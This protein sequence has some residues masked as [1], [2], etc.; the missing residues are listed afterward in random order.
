VPI[1][2]TPTTPE[3]A[4]ALL[5]EADAAGQRVRLMGG[6]TKAGWG[7]PGG[8]AGVD[9]KI[10][11]GRL[12]GIVEHNAADLTAIVRAGTPLGRLQEEL[13]AAGQMMA[14][15]P[16]DPD[17]RATVG[18]V[19]A[20][21]DTG[22][23]R[24]R[25]G[26]PRDQLLGIRVALADGTLARSGGKV[27]KN[28]AGYDLAK[29]FAGSFGTLG[30]VVEVALRLYPLPAARATAMGTSDDPAVLFE[31]VLVLG[32]APLELEALDFRWGAGRGAVLA[33]AG[34]VAARERAERAAGLLAACGLR[35]AIEEE[36]GP[37][38]ARQRAL[39]RSDRGAVV[40]VSGVRS[41]LAAVIAA[42][43]AAGAEVAGRAGLGLLWVRLPEADDGAL[44]AAVEDL[45]AALAPRPCVVLDA[46]E[47]VRRKAD[48]WGEPGA[49]SLMRRVKDRFDPRGT[50][51]P[52]IF[53]GGI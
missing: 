4:A 19:V 36:D 46:P 52:G 26:A 17:V 11:T 27:I 21:G 43:R 41:D 7:R 10:S 35:A 45:R 50:C 44:V 53:V 30:L 32:D 34:G 40:R 8:P 33:R 18:G 12:E 48:V 15:D 14:L 28:V 25:Y 16:P 37:L 42:A 9:V 2:E 1:L 22:P 3:E 24:H 6:G 51:N 13:A 39:Q 29:L 49:L 47:G 23:L 38:W 20:T 31:A 5:R